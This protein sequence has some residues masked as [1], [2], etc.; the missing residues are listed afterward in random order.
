M[1]L[2]AGTKLGPY[3][4]VS[5]LGAGGMGEVYRAR[6]PRLGRDVAIKVLPEHLSKDPQALARFEREARAVAA[7]SHPN[8]LAIFDVGSDQGIT[9]AVT[10]L[11]EGETLRSR[12]GRGALP[13]RQA[14]E[15]GAPI[16]EGLSV[17]H[18]KGIIHRDLKPENIFLTADGRAKILDFGLARWKPAKSPEE[19]GS[20]PTETEPGTVMGTVGYMS[21]EQVRGGIAEAPSD[22][23]SLGCVL[24]EMIAGRRAFSRGTAVQTMSAILEQHPPPLAESGKQIPQELD[25]LVARC[26]AK[27][28]G[29][30][31]QS[32]RDLGFALRDLLG[33]SA[34]SQ[35]AVVPSRLRLKPAIPVAAAL[36]ILLCAAGFYWFHRAGN[37]TDSIAVLPFVN[38]SGNPDM[39][40]L[41]DGITESLI[42]SLSQVPNLAVMSRNSVF[43][44]KG[45]ETDAQAAGQTLKV[46][47]VLTGRVVQRGDGLSISAELIDVRNNRHLWG[48]QYNRKLTDILAVQEDI[49]TE[50]SEKLRFKLTGEEK[51]RLTK[52][53]TQNTEAYQL[54]LL[55]RYH[56][57]KRTPEGFDKGIEYFQRAIE[58]DPNYA[59][60]YAGLADTYN[61]LANFNFALLPPKEAWAKAKAAVGKAL[62]IDD[63]LA[64]AHTSLA[65]GAFFYDWD[66]SNAGKEFKRALELDPSSSFTHHWYSH[67]LMTLGRTQEAFKV[68]QRALELDPLDLPINAHQ[69]W[70]HLWTRQYD[71]AIKP[72][73]KT[74]EM[75]PSFS[76]GQWYL[77][78]VYEQKGAFRDAIAQFE[79]CV[80][81][82]GGNPSMVALLGHAYA[83]ANRRSEAEAILQQLSALSK[84]KYVPSY[85]IAAIYAALGQKDEAFA[86]LDRAYEERDSW[87]D[88][89]G[90]DPRLDGLRSDPRF[91]GLLRR[92]NLV[93]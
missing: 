3:E 51:K 47:A 68:G 7:L 41:G 22:I 20:A 64:A 54:Y 46:Q 83:A 90:L 88:Y 66:W 56:F 15:I 32:A 77:G 16:A 33:G 93:P 5:P 82:T 92:M 71:R 34:G 89:V 73:Q 11:L 26:L 35:P 62:Q 57:N 86:R 49:S 75:A 27:N 30:R 76:V 18:S 58:T 8:I 38:A 2:L 84:Q 91:A 24:Y 37:P 39:E 29:E 79:N 63:T 31:I 48:E 53:Y 52:R 78:L 59:P 28:S 40:Y 70:Y 19:E 10:E 72:L 9:Y 12:S 50:I 23:F 4:I 81:L 6:D 65:I 17:A 1:S 67:Y 61:T 80:R 69:G 87:M 25:R 44:Y 55:G 42:N 43:R 45:R 21:P 36:M 14:V 60:A 85:P 74:I 13:W